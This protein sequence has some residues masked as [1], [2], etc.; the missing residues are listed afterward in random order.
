MKRIGIVAGESS[1]DRLGAG[2][3]RELRVRYP[4]LTVD[5]IVGPHMQAVGAQALYPTERL[6]VM[7]IGE[8]LRR[9]R[10]LRAMRS[11]LVQHYVANPPDVFIGIDAP[12]FN[13]GLELALRTAGIKTVQYVSPQVWAWREWRVKTIARAVNLML[14]LFPFEERYYRAHHVPVR[15]V[16]H[17]LAEEMVQELS[18]DSARQALRLDSRRGIVGILPGSRANEW[19]YHLEPFL[20]AAQWLAQQR[21][22]LS[23]VFAATNERAGEQ[24]R[25]VAHR[26]VPA[27]PVQIVVGQTRD[28]LAAADV[29]LTVSGTATLETLLARRPM[30]VAYRL[31]TLSYLVAR[32][33]VRVPFIALPNLLANRRLVP[34]Y[35][36]SDVQPETLGEAVLAWLDQP[37]AVAALRTEYDTIHAALRLGGSAC[38]AEAVDALVRAA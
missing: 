34:E 28:V 11:A 2:L 7:G 18:R 13:L 22:D 32:T 21:P 6:A 35:I 17:P 10:E 8:I 1:G 30:V 27:L 14:T 12:E 31:G 16:G 38:A 5:G 4:G 29:V 37:A 15:C 24:I 36:Q 9:Y 33:L 23:F 25:S 3:I 19:H 20:K 26:I